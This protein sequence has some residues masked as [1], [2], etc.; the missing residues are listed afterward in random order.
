[1]EIKKGIYKH[2]KTGNLYRV[3]GGGEALRDFRG[4]SV[5]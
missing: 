3:I 1:M 4:F 2:F 5:L